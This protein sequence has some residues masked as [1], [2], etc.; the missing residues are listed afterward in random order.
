MGELAVTRGRQWPGAEGQG[1]QAGLSEGCHSNPGLVSG[2][3][4]DVN[5]PNPPSPMALESQ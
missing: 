2:A 5:A 4:S 1:E 3:A